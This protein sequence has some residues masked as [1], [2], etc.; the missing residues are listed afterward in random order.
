MVGCYGTGRAEFKN[1]SELAISCE[2]ELYACDTN[3]YR[4]Q[5]FDLEL[6]FQRSFGSQEKAAGQFCYPTSIAFDSDGQLYITDS[7]SMN[8]WIQ[9]FSPK[10]EYHLYNTE[11]TNLDAPTGLLIHDD[12]IYTTDYHNHRVMV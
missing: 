1:P 3:N 5:V 12:H 11:H 10:P 7:V 9:C 4:I 8:H 6:E 2:G